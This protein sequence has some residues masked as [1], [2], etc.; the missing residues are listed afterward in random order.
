MKYSVEIPSI[1][2]ADVVVLGGGPA[3]IGAA[4][5]AA[6]NGARTLL[7]EQ[8]GA[9]GGMMTLG[10]V[11]PLCGQSTRK[12]NSLGGIVGEFLTS[13]IDESK[14]YCDAQ[15]KDHYVFSS[16]HVMK[17]VA[18]RMALD[19]GVEILFHASLVDAVRE[20]DRI[21]QVI[22]STKS[23]LGTIR[24]GVFIDTTGDGDLMYRAGEQFVKGSEP[25]VMRS[26]LGTGLDQVHDEDPAKATYGDYDHSGLMQPVTIMFTMGG[27]DVESAQPLCNL[28]V[29]YA[30]IGITKAE[31]LKLPYANTPGFV[32][33][34]TDEVPLPQGRVLFF[35]TLRPGEVVI[36]MTR[37]IGIDGS[38]ACDLTRG[39]IVCQQQVFYVLDF[40]RRFIP[41]F[42]K[43]YLI[44]TA[45]VLGVRETR[46]LVGR[47][48]LTGREA[49]ECRP[50]PDVI[51]NGTY[52]IDIHDPQGRRK[53]IGGTIHQECYDIPYRS[54]TP[55]T[56]ENLLVAGRCISTDHVAH[57]STRV[58]G[59]CMLTGQAAGTA[60]AMAVAL[61]ASVGD[62]P[63]SQLQDRLRAAGVV[64]RNSAEVADVA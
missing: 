23:G 39:E 16:P 8:N 60:A 53:A 27:V 43:S 2:D 18:L 35:Q 63:V 19:A 3:G 48:V 47:Y 55:K 64:F 50:L 34:D 29:T 12:G 61:G 32:V 52:I 25:G 36:N 26:L 49:I 58:Q 14:R 59:T 41:G 4:I 6:R 7:V 38:D 21:T 51:A 15:G 44:E 57:S 56:V 22:V 1:A 20:G 10:L 11:M 46:R 37:V 42:E 62:I 33:D 45:D 9:L 30:Q 24:G 28:K 13:V 17:H 40:L 5:A 54:L 31:F